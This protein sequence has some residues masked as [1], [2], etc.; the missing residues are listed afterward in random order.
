MKR[1]LL[2]FITFTIALIALGEV[3]I[4]V[5]KL[6]PDI[7]H[8][9]VDDTG[10][11]RYIPGQKGYFSKVSQWEVNTYGW[12]GI[13]ETQKAPIISIIGDSYIENLMNPI[14]CNQGSILKS[15][16]DDY[17]F[18]EAGRS[19][20]TFIEALQITKLLDSTIKPS[21]HLIYVSEEDL[22]ES[23]AKYRLKDRM[24]I[25]LASNKIVN[26][27]LK[28]P[29][30]KKV[31][32]NIKAFYYLYLRFPIFVSE[33]NK[34]STHIPIKKEKVID[35]KFVENLLKYSSLNYDAK[36]IVLVWHPGTSESIA[37][38]A[39][40]YGFATIGLNTTG[41]EKNWAVSSVDAHWSCYGHHEVA[42]QIKAYLATYMKTS[43]RKT[44]I[45]LNKE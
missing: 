24:Q 10:I 19:G 29:G 39:Q 7:P 23:N 33:S 36:K 32:Y 27:E 31:L 38:L 14:I 16:F 18:F 41:D 35:Y 30:I 25:N 37:A 4:R 34:E 6:T 3:V 44:K 13:A 8:L 45:A 9:Y 11:Q 1:F 12:L 17:G 20:V 2:T 43:E 5:F 15:Y 42:K 40:K 22:Y 28:A 21:I 26:G